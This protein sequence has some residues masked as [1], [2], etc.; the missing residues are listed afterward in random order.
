[1][2]YNS[3]RADFRH[4]IQG[5]RLM[6]FASASPSGWNVLL[7]QGY[8]GGGFGSSPTDPLNPY[9]SLGGPG[10]QQPRRGSKSWLWILGI[11]GGVMLVLCAGC[12]IASYFA[13]QGMSSFMGGMVQEQVADDPVIQEHIGDVES[14][15][16]NIMA[17]GQ[18]AERNPP[19]PGENRMVFDIKG[20][21]ASGQLVGTQVAQPGPGR[22]LRDM[23]LRVGGQE[24][25]L[26]D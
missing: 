7:S 5:L 12:G 16:L 18:E 26:A 20:S 21:K 3:G 19:P 15:T 13:W 8:G 1:M 14:V 2:W 24:Y 6:P 23:K 11:V 25:P 17:T 10:G 4:S 22:V 9:A